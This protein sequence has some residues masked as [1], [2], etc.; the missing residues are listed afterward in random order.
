MKR[1]PIILT[2]EQRRELEKFV[3]TGVH[4]VRLVNRAK[5]ILALDTSDGRKAMK[6]EEIAQHVGVSRQTV[7][8]AQRAFLKADDLS[9]FLQR[10]KRMTPPVPSKITGEIEAKIIALACGQVPEGFSRWTIQLIAD[11]CVEL[12]YLD[13]IANST[14]CNLLKKRDLN[15]I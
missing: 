8:V 14:V 11:K 4:N 15:L 5:I 10:K 9:E 7:T 6:Q 2:A 12:H 3:K 1:G 13:S